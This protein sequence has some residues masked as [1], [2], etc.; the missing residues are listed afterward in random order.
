MQID[1]TLKYIIYSLLGI[2]FLVPF[3]VDT[4]QL[5]P[6]ISGKA[7]AFRVLVEGIF[8]IWLILAIRN[9]A[10]RPKFSL[11]FISVTAFVVLIGISNIFGQ[12]PFNSFWSNHERME[13]YVNI[14]HLYALFIAIGSTIKNREDWDKFIL[15]SFIISIGILFNAFQQH[16]GYKQISQGGR[17]DATFG[18]PIYLA[19]Y[20]IFHIFFGIYLINIKGFIKENWQRIT[21]LVFVFIHAFVLYQ[22]N[23]RGA[24]LGLIGGFLLAGILNIFNSKKENKKVWLSSIISVAA[25]LVIIFGFFFVKEAEFVKNNKVLKR[26]AEISLTSGTSEARLLNWSI[27]ID[28]FKEKPVLGWGMGNYSYVFDKYYKPEMYG[29]ETWFDHVHNTVLDWL[30]AG[31]VVG[32][33]LYLSILLTLVWAIWT[34]KNYS[35][36]EKNI[37]IGLVAAYFIQNLFVFDNQVSYI[38]FFILLAIFH[39]QNNKEISI[40]K[41][42]LDHNVV[43]SA[44]I[45]IWILLPVTIY[46]VNAPTYIASANTIKSLKELSSLNQVSPSS[47]QS[48]VSN[49]VNRIKK[50]STI[51]SFAS[52]EIRTKG[53]MEPAFALVQ[54]PENYLAQSEKQS[55]VQFAF[56]E[57]M[58]EMDINPNDAKTAYILGIYLGNFGDHQNANL[59]LQKAVELSPKKQVLQIALAFNYFN[60]GQKDKAI[61][62]AKNAYELADGDTEKNSKYDLLWVDYLRIVTLANPELSKKLIDEEIKAGRPGRV[63]VLLKKGIELSPDNYQS[64]VSL[65]AFYYNQGDKEKSL[66][67]LNNAKTKFPKLEKEILK[68]ISDIES[69]KNILGNKY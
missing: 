59:F 58:K 6:F 25:I 48:F 15:T 64:Y 42:K 54:L 20:N 31:G 16:F 68:L 3:I 22:T 27:A 29:N 12:N 62:V 7:F 2:I 14:L 43:Y 69:G 8:F 1:N 34:N 13:G 21:I 67:V 33:F 10:Y 19:V 36:F 60:L 44:T 39:S 40:F 38:Y 65:S 61:E 9:P 32:L 66:E 50:T 56:N 30:I 26:F 28:G 52:F 63:E 55:Y 11:I 49:I 24:V 45:L 35:N 53:I 23:T 5:F 47:A 37:F 51:N 46:F 57:M 18:N 4:S 41:N 17:L